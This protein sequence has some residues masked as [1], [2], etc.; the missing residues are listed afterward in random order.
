MINTGVSPN[1]IAPGTRHRH[2]YQQGGRGLTPLPRRV[3]CIGTMKGGTATPGVLYDKIADA[4][5]SDAL[6]GVGS[7]LAL[8]MRKSFEVGARIGAGP[9]VF[10]IGVAEPGAG[11][12]RTHTFTVTGTATASGNIYFAVKGISFVVGVSIGNDPTTIASAMAAEVNKQRSVLPVTPAS[13]AGVVTFTAVAKGENGNDVAFWVSPTLPAGVSIASATGVAGAGV[14]DPTSAMASLLGVD[15]DAIASENHKTADVGIALSHVTTAWLPESK[16]WRFVF[17]GETGSLGTA[18]PLAT[19]ANDRSIVVANAINSQ[20]LSSEVAAACAF[21]FASKTKPN[22]GF[23]FMELALAPPTDIT[24]N[25]TT[26]AINTALL[27]GVTPLR[28]VVDSSSRISRPGV[29]AI[30]KMVTTKTTT[31]GQPDPTVRDIAVPNTGA[32]L[33]R[34]IDAAYAQRFSASQFPD[35]VDFT[36]EIIGQVADMITAI[37]F[38]MQ[39]RNML[40]NVAADIKFM[41]LERDPDVANR[42][43]ADITYTVVVGLDQVAVVHRVKVGG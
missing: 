3:A 23:N 4:A 36:D 27:A 25:P 43:N 39:D 35:G 31:G 40:R 38:A 7:P 42:L 15:L 30:Q 8:M 24:T 2:I 12:A 29:M 33:S 13:A 21:A 26:A 22:A 18:T 1:D 6:F 28:A 5:E 34:Q 9:Q 20:S 14:A 16:Y 32:Y 41:V 37:M 10:A 19:A 11:T 17:F